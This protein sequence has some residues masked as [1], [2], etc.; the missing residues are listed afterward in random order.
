MMSFNSTRVQ[1]PANLSNP[2]AY[3]DVVSLNL[4]RRGIADVANGGDNNTNIISGLLRPRKTITV[5]T[6]N[7]RT[8]SSDLKINEVIAGAE[9]HNIDII[10]IQEHR[11]Y[12]DNIDIRYND[13]G[14]WSLI[15]SSATKSSVNATIGGVGLLL[16]PRA[17]ASLNY[18]TKVSSR[19]ITAT[20]NSNPNLTIISCYSPTNCSD[21]EDVENFYDDLSEAIRLIPKHNLLMIGGDF[22]AQL[23]MQSNLVSY[24][25]QSNRNGAF[26]ESIL[27]QFNLRATNTKFQKRPGKL[28]TIEYANGSKGQIDYI[29]VNRKWLNSITNSEAYSSFETVNSD[30]RIVSARV[31]LSVR[32]NK[33]KRRTNVYC[34]DA[35]RNDSNIQ[36]EF[37]ITLKN[38]FEELCNEVNLDNNDKYSNIVTACKEAAERVLPKRAKIRTLLPWEDIDV[39][40][41][42]NKVKEISTRK[43]RTK[44]VADKAKF[45]DAIAELDA[46]YLHK[47]ACYVENKVAELESAHQQHKSKLV[48]KIAN[49]VTKRKTSDS[50]RL[51]ASNPSAR[52]EAWKNHFSTLLGTTQLPDSVSSNIQT[53]VDHELP[54]NTNDFTLDELNTCIRCL[55]NNKATGL[56]DIPGEVWKAR[57]LDNELLDFCNRTLNGDKPKIWS[58]SGII[59]IPKK[60]DLS[61]PSNYRGISLTPIAAKIY[62]KL[63]L[64]RLRPHLDPLLRPNQNG[65]RQGRGTTS[66]ILTIRRII[67]GVKSKNLGAVLTFV[68]FKKAFDSIDRSK[69]MAILRAYGVP[70]KIVRAINIIYSNTIAKVISP[71]GMTDFFEILAGVLQG[72]TLAPFL[73]I[74]VV[75]YV[76]RVTV[77]EH[78][79]LG[80]TLQ[81]GRASRLPRK[82]NTSASSTK[83]ITDTGYADDLCMLSDTLDEAQTLL[84][85]LESAA[86]LVGLVMNENKTEYMCFHQGT[87]SPKLLAQSGYELKRVSDFL[88][89]GSWVNTSE[90]DLSV[91]IAKAWAA[92]NKMDKIWKSK[93]DRKLKVHFFRATVESVLLY[94]AECWTLTKQQEKR[95]DGSYTR[96][97]R[98]SLNISWKQRLTN[99]ALYGNIPPVSQTVRDRRLRFSGHCL[100]A[101]NECI[102][103]VLFWKPKHGKRSVGRPAKTYIDQLERDTGYTSDELMILMADRAVWRDIVE[104]RPLQSP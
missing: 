74:V 68:D 95:L 97:L 87:P 45:T 66:Q 38:R 78:D 16:S 14:K 25:L 46:L 29:L 10:C 96:L 75:D 61:N 76:L 101:T 9:Q 84:Q 24:H 103:D 62:N 99:R 55:K 72:D 100:R 81:V 51:K 39:L 43:R 58:A 53:I 40:N 44:S 59:P 36:N 7:V 69:L 92:S 93:L 70:E 4:P 47:Q 52:I 80:L 91:R 86:M 83:H 85:R 2:D 18:V 94:G 56:D 67:E 23:G 11:H 17:K 90:R 20:F 63:L 30:H 32:A 21:L 71:D 104:N 79:H 102:S 3:D 8:L 34:W 27:T 19:I 50:G 12:H 64:N 13:I 60:G 37:S 26:L 48:W 77:G 42:R 15:T 82:A 6:F 22:N 89:L 57:I 31:R 54:I 33:P 73:F 98:A 88:Y 49:E 5:S 41:C 35:L 28:W 65:F 1:A